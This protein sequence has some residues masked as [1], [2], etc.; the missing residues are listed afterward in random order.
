[1]LVKSGFA[2]L[3]G[4]KYRAIW[5]MQQAQD[6]QLPETFEKFC[7]IGWVSKP[8]WLRILWSRMKGKATS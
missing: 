7:D 4:S 6:A 8:G 3:L 1:M 2:D 5:E